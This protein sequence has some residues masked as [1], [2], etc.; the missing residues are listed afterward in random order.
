MP[1]VKSMLH[2]NVKHMTDCLQRVGGGLFPQDSRVI[3]LV[4]GAIFSLQL[5]SVNNIL[6]SINFEAQLHLFAWFLDQFGVLDDG[7]QPYPGAIT[8]SNVLKKARMIKNGN[9]DSNVVTG[10]LIETLVVESED[11][12]QVVD[13][14]GL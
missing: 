7:K 6:A 10:T 4:S 5:S 12:V 9:R 1:D 8:T 3:L 13:K 14:A 2:S 11:L